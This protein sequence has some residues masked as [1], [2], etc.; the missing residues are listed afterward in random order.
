MVVT[1]YDKVTKVTHVLWRRK[2]NGQEMWLTPG[3][4][5]LPSNILHPDQDDQWELVDDE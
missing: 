2:D 4:R 3:V 5:P 1:K